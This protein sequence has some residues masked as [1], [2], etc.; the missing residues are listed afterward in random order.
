MV[1]T[2]PFP[3]FKNALKYSPQGEK[4]KKK[5][6]KYVHLNNSVKSAVGIIYIFLVCTH[7]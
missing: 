3:K 1:M 7:S 6:K 2:L 5:P 4:K